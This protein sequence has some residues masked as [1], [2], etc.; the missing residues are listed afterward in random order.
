[1]NGKSHFP[2]SVGE[3]LSS[4]EKTLVLMFLVSVKRIVAFRQIRTICVIV[5]CVV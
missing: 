1:M 3:E 4:E 5:H 2:M